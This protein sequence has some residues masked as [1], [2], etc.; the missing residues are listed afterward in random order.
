MEKIVYSVIAPGYTRRS[1]VAYIGTNGTTNMKENA[2]QF[3][4]KED[5]LVYIRKV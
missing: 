3:E 2:L 5:A 4:S 1:G